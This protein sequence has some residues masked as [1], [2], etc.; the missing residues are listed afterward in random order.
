MIVSLP[1]LHHK[2]ILRKEE[3]AIGIIWLFQLSAVLGISLGYKDW[4]I[5]KTPLN[6]SLQLFLVF[7]L[8][9]IKSFRSVLIVCC[10]FF[11]GMTAEWLGVNQ[12]LLFGHYDYGENLGIKLFGVPLL[13]GL[14]F[15]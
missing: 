10:L 5:E 6:L 2:L 12:Q 15:R 11:I 7:W 14:Y 8:F 3:L 13:I 1:F 9:S 4:F